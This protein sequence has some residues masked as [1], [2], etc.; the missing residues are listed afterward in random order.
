[1]Y[2]C[3]AEGKLGGPEDDDT[4]SD[5]TQTE[6]HR[7]AAIQALAEALTG[8]AGQ[9]APGPGPSIRIHISPTGTLGTGL[10]HCHSIDIT[11]ARAHQLADQADAMSCYLDSE[12]PDTSTVL[13]PQ[14]VAELTELVDL[15]GAVLKSTRPE[16][17]SAVTQA[18]DD[19]FGD[20][21]GPED[22]E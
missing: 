1:M 6:A 9:D 13:A 17:R 11:P 18:I 2:G 7:N 14:T 5:A 8:L 16:S 22:P 15:T 4:G 19:M 3:G 20:V 10:E 12:R 21:P